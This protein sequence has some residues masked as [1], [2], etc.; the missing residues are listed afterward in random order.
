MGLLFEVLSDP[1]LHK[2]A[3][4]GYK[5]VGQSIDLHGKED[6]LVVRE[7]GTFWNEVTTDNY[8]SMRPNIDAELAADADEFNEGG[9]TWCQRDVKRLIT[10]YPPRHAVDR[11]LEKLGEDFQHDD[12]HCLHDEDG[13][14]AVAEGGQSATESSDDDEPA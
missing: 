8:P 10:P 14:A 2:Q 13:E 9:I 6:E 3:S 5:R 12:V 11:V 4:E 1:G 7:A